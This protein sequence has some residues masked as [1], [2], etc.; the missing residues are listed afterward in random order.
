MKEIKEIKMFCEEIEND[1]SKC[2]MKIIKH[3]IKVGYAEVDTTYAFELVKRHFVNK[4]F[5]YVKV[6]SYTEYVRDA[7]EKQEKMELAKSS[8]IIVNINNLKRDGKRLKLADKEQY[9]SLMELKQYIKE[10]HMPNSKNIASFINADIDIL[11]T[12][13][14]PIQSRTDKSR[15][16]EDFDE[17]SMS[18]VKQSLKQLL[19]LSEQEIIMYGLFELRDVL[20]RT[21]FTEVQRA[22][23]YLWLN[24]IN[25]GNHHKDLKCCIE[26]LVNNLNN[27]YKETMKRDII[28]D[29]EYLLQ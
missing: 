16:V 20:L 1:Y 3:N 7:E 23:L 4:F 29:N 22:S 27:H 13:Q 14:N 17:W 18:T 8:G 26:K 11:L 10:H 19:F 28:P 21:D 6:E 25:I 15:Y 5:R 24:N 9:L 12:E 2:L